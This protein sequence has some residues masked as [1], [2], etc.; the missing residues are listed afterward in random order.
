MAYTRIHA[1]KATVDKSIAYI[2]NPGKTDG[3]LYVSSF[4]CSAKTAHLEFAFANGKNIK[5]GDNLAHH[6]IQSFAPGEVSFE[7]AHQIGTELADKLLGGKYSYVIATHIE[8]DH[9][10]NHIIFCA[11]DNIEHK[12]YNTCKKSY[13]N[14]RKLSDELC[15]EHQLSTIVPCQQRG[16]KHTEWEAAKNGKS[17]KDKLRRDIDA[18]IK[19]SI[20]YEDFIRLIRLKGYE[21]KGE[22][23][24]GSLSY[25]SFRPAG[26]ERF[27]RGSDRSLGHSYTRE[28][29]KERIETRDKKRTDYKQRNYATRNLIDTSSEDFTESPGLQ[30]WA[31]IENLKIAASAYA[32]AQSITALEQQIAEKK[33]LSNAAR[34]ELVTLEHEMKPYAEMLK[35][36]EQYEANKPYHLRSQKSKNPDDYFRRH[37]SE[38]LLYDG[39]KNMLQKAGINIKTMNLDQMRTDFHALEKKKAELQ[40]SYRSAEK[41]ISDMEKKMKNLSQYLGLQ[42]SEKQQAQ[43]KNQPPHSL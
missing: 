12:K 37:E 29:I 4:G 40:K 6:L 17:W 13:Y 39:A 2:C 18:I 10:H 25:I 19:L 15:K 24:G 32:E 21:V 5:T 30:H 38:L 27:V 31:D 41:D 7:E 20:S 9:V 11:T 28:S 22:E 16:K 34:T 26:A 35:Y 1:I 43:R 14:I 8:K 42:L 23:I 33:S 3:E 36:A